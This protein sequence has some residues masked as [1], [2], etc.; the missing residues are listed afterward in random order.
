MRAWVAV[1]PLAP[2]RRHHE[3]HAGQH[4]HRAENA[5]RIHRF[6]RLQH[7]ELVQQQ[8]GGDLPEHRQ[9]DHAGRSD[10]RDQQG[11]AGHVNRADRAAGPDPRRQFQ[12]ALLGD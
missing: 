1:P 11:E 3:H 12:A 2:P 7:A 6:R 9:A 10:A 5:Q 8:R 4:Q